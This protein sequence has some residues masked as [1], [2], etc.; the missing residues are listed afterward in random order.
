VPEKIVPKT[1]ASA[2]SLEDGE[3]HVESIGSDTNELI[4]EPIR[5][6]RIF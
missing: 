3:L 4:I 5:D 1:Q 2:A 6:Q